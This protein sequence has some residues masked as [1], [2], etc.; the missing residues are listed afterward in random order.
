MSRF[1]I[2]I[3]EYM[4]G[5]TQSVEEPTLEEIIEFGK[6]YVFKNELNV[7]NEE[8]RDYFVGAFILHYFLSEIGQP[9]WGLWRMRL[10]SKLYE[11]KNFLNALFENDLK[12]IFGSYTVSHRVGH[13]VEDAQSQ[14]NLDREYGSETD[15]SQSGDG[16]HTEENRNSETRTDNLKDTSTYGSQTKDTG[17]IVNQDSGSDRRVN[18]GSTEQAHTG[19]D[20]SYSQ[21]YSTENRGGYDTITDSDSDTDKSNSVDL[22]SDTPMGSVGNVLV[23]SPADATGQGVSRATSPST[24]YEYL[25]NARENDATD[26]KQHDGTSRTDYNSNTRTDNNLEDRDV[27]NSKQTQTDDTVETNTYGRGTTETRNITSARTGSD[28][29]AHTGTVQS[30]GTENVSAQD[31]SEGTGHSEVAGTDKSTM[32]GSLTATRDQNEDTESMTISFDL[33]LRSQS[34]MN[35]VWDIFDPLFMGIL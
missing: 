16:S 17:T 18:S 34:L 28:V 22:Y 27:Y 5:I 15:S 4:Q 25:S 23:S 8:Y 9:T 6:Q 7:L 14:R 1:T 2:S 26:V 20:T 30:N 12:G 13:N 21:G 11:N 32:N 24:Q 31:H 10:V 19:Y 35:K 29:D 33:V 3:K